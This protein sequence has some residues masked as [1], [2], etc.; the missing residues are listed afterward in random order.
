MAPTRTACAWLSSR[1]TS[2]R[3]VRCF[4]RSVAASLRNLFKLFFLTMK[5]TAGLSAGHFSA[6]TGACHAPSQ[7]LPMRR[8]VVFVYSFPFFFFS[9]QIVPVLRGGVASRRGHE[10]TSKPLDRT[11]AREKEL[12]AYLRLSD[13]HGVANCWR[14]ISF[15]LLHTRRARLILVAIPLNHPALAGLVR[16][17]VDASVMTL[18][19]EKQAFFSY[20]VFVHFSL[21]LFRFKCPYHARVASGHVCLGC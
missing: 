8:T 6:L 17:T 9:F 2:S 20:F 21:A 13:P 14:L 16:V 4:K 3:P 19:L 1:G 10:G 7:N 18:V 15:C 5:R 11:F 12:S